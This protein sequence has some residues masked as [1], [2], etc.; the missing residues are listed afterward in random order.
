M[1]IGDILVQAVGEL[2]PDKASKIGRQ[3][4]GLATRR[5]AARDGSINLDGVTIKGFTY[6][7]SPKGAGDFIQDL[8]ALVGREYAFNHLNY[9]GHDGFLQALDID[10][11]DQAEVANLREYTISGKFMP[12]SLYERAIILDTETV[13]NDFGLGFPPTV[14]LPVA[15][16]NVKVRSA[17]QS[18]PL[19]AWVNLTGWDGSTPAAVTVPLYRAFPVFSFPDGAV[20]GAT[21]VVDE[22][23]Y[24]LSKTR[25]NAQNEYIAFPTTVGVT[26]PRGKYKVRARI[27]KQT[28]GESIAI[29]VGTAADGSTILS[30]T[31]AT[32]STSWQLIESEEWECF[33]D[34][35]IYITLKKTA[36]DTNTVDLDYLYLIP[37]TTCWITYDVDSE[38]DA[39]EVKVYDAPLGTATEA[40]WLRVFTPE[41][42]FPAT[43]H[44]YLQNPFIRLKVP[45]DLTPVSA[46]LYRTADATKYA[47][48]HPYAFS[49]ILSTGMTMETI[50]PNTAEFTLALSSGI[51][52]AN[53]VGD[54]GL[55]AYTLAPHLLGIELTKIGS[56]RYDYYLAALGNAAKLVS[57][58]AATVS[59]N[60]TT[61]SITSANGMLARLNTD[62]LDV[63][64]LA[65]STAVSVYG[66]DSYP[67]ALLVGASI[68]AT[69][70]TMRYGLIPYAT[71]YLYKGAANLVRTTCEPVSLAFA[72][73]AVADSFDTA[74]VD[75]TV[76]WS[77]AGGTLVATVGTSS[78]VRPIRL[79]GKSFGSA[80]YEM[81]VAISAVSADPRGVLV[82]FDSTYSKTSSSNYYPYNGYYV[83]LRVATGDFTLKLYKRV[84]GVDTQL[85]ST[86]TI[87]AFVAGT[88]YHLTI[89]HNAK[90]GALG[91]QWDN[92]G[93]NDISA[94]D[95]THTGG[96]FWMGTVFGGLATGT[97]NFDN[98]AITPKVAYLDAFG[99]DSSARYFL[100]TGFSIAGGVLTCSDANKVAL[101]RSYRYREGTYVVKFTTIT[102]D[103]KPR[104][105]FQ[106]SEP[107]FQV[108][109]GYFIEFDTD[110][111]TMTFYKFAGATETAL[112]TTD[113]DVTLDPDT[114]YTATLV[115]DASG[116]MSCTVGA[117]TATASDVTYTNFGYI[118]VG[119]GNAAVENQFDDLSFI[120]IEHPCANTT[121]YR[122]AQSNVFVDDFN[123]DTDAEWTKDYETWTRDTAT[124]RVTVTSA[125][126]LRACRCLN[127]VKFS[128]GTYE[129]KIKFDDATNEAKYAGI[130][131]GW[132]GTSLTTGNP[133]NCYQ[134]ILDPYADK[135]YVYERDDAG[136]SS[137]LSAG[138]FAASM[139]Y[140]TEYTLKAIWNSD[141][142]IAVYLD[143]VLI[144]TSTADTTFT[145]GYFG[146]YVYQATAAN[147]DTD[148][149]DIVISARESLS[150][151]TIPTAIVLGGVGHG[152]RF[153]F[154]ECA[155]HLFREDDV[156]QGEYTALV[157]SKTTNIAGDATDLHHDNLT[158]AATLMI[159]GTDLYTAMANAATYGYTRVPV[160]IN[161][162]DDA[163][164]LEAAVKRNTPTTDNQPA[165]AVDLLALMPASG[166]ASA[167]CFPQDI[168]FASMCEF[169]DKRRVVVRGV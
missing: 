168:A 11:P 92:S 53:S 147:L 146:L 55:Y 115:I 68:V 124:G 137:D 36:A 90:T 104:I 127:S 58:P 155:C 34:Q 158:D 128:Y 50:V 61:T 1:Y 48:A 8:K 40:S 9:A 64:I 165:V 141:G 21:E 59:A 54:R 15:A 37:T 130:N 45:L 69:G 70:W 12:R 47:A 129:C 149:R 166:A 43:S 73:G 157:R 154:T 60:G 78:T 96:L 65:K 138:G 163:D 35:T 125:T 29:K 51:S 75:S 46:R 7:A 160:R 131:I 161:S 27:K 169:S 87:P 57:A 13:V 84:N 122:G 150:N 62:F 41:H 132:D 26:I 80:D 123:W 98:I 79:K 117:V 52:A 126:K 111:D 38:R 83:W 85:G 24:R 120:G 108:G 97:V 25:L 107:G 135:I 116:N 16:Y 159:G 3:I 30:D 6:N 56:F 100:E 140:D 74:V 101:L 2:S 10:S 23:C 20:S 162:D 14:P 118:G 106:R 143:G 148:F 95:T 4:K 121:V 133:K 5:P 156:P 144:G 67:G 63:M 22:E 39:G 152:A 136:A 112:A 17:W 89:T 76:A 164:Y 167:T 134:V 103:S 33:T 86:Y 82:F 88:E 110:A 49:D 19:S 72:S 99:A 42:R 114:Q 32:S 142:T 71:T 93:T 31:D 91:V 94:T 77:I 113:D 153:D 109:T 18:V 105:Y 139:A 81:D 119:T 102:S 44:I 66:A 151:G 145:S 28:A